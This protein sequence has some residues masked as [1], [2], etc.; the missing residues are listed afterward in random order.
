MD[1][2]QA[3]APEIA[4]YAKILRF[5][6]CTIGKFLERV[7]VALVS[8][9]VL[10]TM[11]NY[12]LHSIPFFHNLLSVRNFFNLIYLDVGSSEVRKALL[13]PTPSLHRQARRIK[14]RERLSTLTTRTLWP[15]LHSVN[16]RSEIHTYILACSVVIPCLPLPNAK[17]QLHYFTQLS[18]VLE[19]SNCARL[20]IWRHTRFISNVG[21]CSTE[22]WKTTSGLSAHPRFCWHPPYSCLP[23]LEFDPFIS[24]SCCPSV[25]SFWYRLRLKCHLR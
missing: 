14:R 8:D 4:D 19:A 3:A 22:L 17:R 25:P 5:C 7:E 10:L 20:C 11:T 15:H 9:F 18:S 6:Q 16:K 21:H 13:P 1:E 2:T 24:E 12:D 23:L